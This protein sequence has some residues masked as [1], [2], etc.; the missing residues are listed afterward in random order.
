MA[1]W[2]E[3]HPNKVELDYTEDL[4]A[5]ASAI[6]KLVDEVRALKEQQIECQKHLRDAIKS[7]R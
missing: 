7:L 5:I 3:L 6:N 2:N 1:K 4:K